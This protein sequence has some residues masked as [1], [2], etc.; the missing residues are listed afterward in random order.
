MNRS[1]RCGVIAL[2]KTVW[3][4]RQRHW[5]ANTHALMRWQNNAQGGP[6]TENDNERSSAFVTEPKHLTA[7]GLIRDMKRVDSCR[8]HIGL[9]W[10]S[11]LNIAC[12]TS[13]AVELKRSK[14]PVDQLRA[15]NLPESDPVFLH[16]RAGMAVIVADPTNNAWSMADVLNV[17]NKACS[18][19]TPAFFQVADVHTGAISWISAES[20][21]HIVPKL[22]GPC[23][24]S[25]VR[26]S[27]GS[28]WD[29]SSISML[30]Q[31]SSAFRAQARKLTDESG[32]SHSYLCT[33]QPP[34]WWWISAVPVTLFSQ[35]MNN[36]AGDTDWNP[37]KWTSQEEIYG[38]CNKVDDQ[39]RIWFGYCHRSVHDARRLKSQTK[40]FGRPGSQHRLVRSLLSK[41]ICNSQKNS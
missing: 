39:S 2:E 6:A 7:Q 33:Q 31:T 16:V 23:P 28:A 38:S 21:T 40:Q 10:G 26:L 20:V 11:R 22:W 30:K 18:P 25:F 36:I 24:Q 3:R 29:I 5:S 27:A 37:S 35:R 8:P 15:I 13:H 34:T 4:Y 19:Q 12:S 14:M 9:V 41:N 17:D 32:R 1:R